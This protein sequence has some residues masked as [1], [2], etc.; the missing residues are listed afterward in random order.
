[1]EYPLFTKQTDRE[2][3]LS[4]TPILLRGGGLLFGDVPLADRLS[5]FQATTAYPVA[6]TGP[7]TPPLLQADAAS[8]TSPHL[9]YQ[10][11]F[12][13]VVMIFQVLAAAERLCQ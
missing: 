8:T 11:F 2:S 1:M 5:R 4:T 9:S 12:W 6:Q 7:V 3:M 13:L 10:G